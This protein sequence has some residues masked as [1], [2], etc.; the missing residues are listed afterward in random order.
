MSPNEVNPVFIPS[1]ETE[2][3]LYQPSQ[4]FVRSE[5][6]KIDESNFE[7]LVISIFPDSQGLYAGESICLL[8]T[9]NFKPQIDVRVLLCSHAFHKECILKHIINEETKIYPICNQKYS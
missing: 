8:C 4:N 7:E 6:I 9:V 5:I 3:G 1:A 2:N